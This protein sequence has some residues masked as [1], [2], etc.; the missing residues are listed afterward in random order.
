MKKVLKTMMLL[1]AVTIGTLI[2]T[3]VSGKAAT[4]TPVSIVTGGENVNANTNSFV[5]PANNKQSNVVSVAVPSAGTVYFNVLS[6]MLTD[7]V[8]LSLWKDK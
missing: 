3:G 4:I 6:S 2:V 1:F 8:K 5:I 7:N